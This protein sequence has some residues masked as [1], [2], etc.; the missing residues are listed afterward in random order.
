MPKPFKGKIELDIRDSVPDW[1][2]FLPDKAPETVRQF[3]MLARAG[4]YDGV[5]IHRVA[6]NFVM[7]TGALAYRA[8]LTP[9]Q[10]KLVR[11]LAPEFNDTANVPGVVSMARG[12]DPASANTSFFICIGECRGLDGKYT[13]F[14]RV[15]TGMDVVK[16]IADAPV[17]GEAPR[18]K[19]MVTKVTLQRSSS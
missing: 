19:I 14:A 11:N 17:D 3:L 8:P 6:P 2:A 16:A 7:Q 15:L 5:G 12:D 9:S 1:D 10:Q 4:V 18:E 13:A